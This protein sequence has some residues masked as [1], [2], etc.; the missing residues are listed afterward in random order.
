M[1]GILKCFPICIFLS[2]NTKWLVFQDASDRMANEAGGFDSRDHGSAIC[3]VG[4][5]VKKDD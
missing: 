1:V 2:K 4:L 3:G 5:L